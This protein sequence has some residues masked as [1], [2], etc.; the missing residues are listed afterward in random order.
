[1]IHHH[2]ARPIQD[3]YTGLIVLKQLIYYLNGA[4]LL[5]S[6]HLDYTFCYVRPENKFND[7]LYAD[8]VRE[9][10]NVKITSLDLFSYFT[11][12]TE[13]PQQPLPDGWQLQECSASDLWELEQFYNHHS[14]GLLLKVLSLD[15]FGQEES[16]EKI[17]ADMGFVRRWKPLALHYYDDLKAIII[18]EESDVA[19]NLSELINGFKVMVL[20]PEMPPATIFAAISDMT[21]NVRM[22]SFPVMIYPE[23]YAR[24]SGLHDEKQY[25]LWILNVQHGNEYMRY[26]ART[27][28]IKLD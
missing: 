23:S 11:Y 21:K 28:R 5:P 3:K 25:Y 26:L 24:Q 13:T 15:H 19:I 16:L 14:G 7:R 27:Y 8:F 12:K 2:A 6:A 9:Q 10:S 20:D 22:K 4:H 17:Y 18:A 1:M